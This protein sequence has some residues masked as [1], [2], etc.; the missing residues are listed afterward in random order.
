[1]RERQVRVIPVMRSEPDVGQFVLALLAMLDDQQSSDDLPGRIA[2][3]LG[4]NG[5]VDAEPGD[6]AA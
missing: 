1:M 2:A 6:S 4:P 5:D 3:K